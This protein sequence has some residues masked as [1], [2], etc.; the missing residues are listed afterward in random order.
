M[1]QKKILVIGYKG[2]MGEVA[3]QAINT[4]PALIYVGGCGSTDNLEEKINSTLPD[5][6]IELSNYKSVYKNSLLAIK[7]N[8]NIVIGASGL[9]QKEISDLQKLCG[10]KKLGALI[11]PNFS[12]GAILMMH[13]SAQIAKFFP[14]AAITE[15]HHLNKKDAPSAT[16]IATA[17]IIAKNRKLAPI[18]HIS[19]EIL[20]GSLG[21]D[22]NNTP[23]HSLRMPGKLAHQTVTFANLGESL[24]ITHDTVSREAFTSGINFALEQVST[25]KSLHIGLDTI[26]NI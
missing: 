6:I 18:T 1:K 17:E 14:N 23:I 11:V 10:Q 21:G 24:T 4:N 13:C 8:I 3:I 7:H 22:C 16:A 25:L 12:M 5:I 15:T 20:A 26:L 2:K 9:Q 19:E